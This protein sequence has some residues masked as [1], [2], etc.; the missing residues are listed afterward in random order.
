MSYRII[1]CMRILWRLHLTDRFSMFSDKASWNNFS[2]MLRSKIR[3]NVFIAVWQILCTSLNIKMPEIESAYYMYIENE[4]GKQYE[5][6]GLWPLLKIYMYHE[7]GW[8]KTI[9]VHM[10]N[11]HCLWM[12]FHMVMKKRKKET[13]KKQ[14]LVCVWFIQW[15]F[16]SYSEL[17]HSQQHDGS[18]ICMY[19]AWYRKYVLSW[20]CEILAWNN[21]HG[22]VALVMSSL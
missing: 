4:T 7:H 21:I 20:A 13:T 17:N 1:F 9:C 22:A 6:Q 8:G 16:K 5:M 3:G 19:E 18:D 12:Y 14:L 15:L 2:F 10:N 11:V